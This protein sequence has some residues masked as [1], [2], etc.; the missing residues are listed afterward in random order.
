MRQYLSSMFNLIILVASYFLLADPLFL[1]NYPTIRAQFDLAFDSSSYSC[2]MDQAA[3]SLFT[4]VLTGF[5]LKIAAPITINTI[6]HIVSYITKKPFF[7]AEFNMPRSTAYLLDFMGMIFLSI[8]FAPLAVV[9]VPLFIF[10]KFKMEI[11]IAFAFFQKPQKPWKSQKAGEVHRPLIAPNYNYTF[12]SPDSLSCNLLCCATDIRDVLPHVLSDPGLLRTGLLLLEP[13]L[14]QELLDTGQ[15][16]RA[17]LGQHQQLCQQL[18]PR[19]GGRLLHLG[20]RQ[21][22]HY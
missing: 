7:R 12:N 4:L 20:Q 5:S 14:R 11:L 1:A 18:H 6:K 19:H 3:Q 17:V 13:D 22:R 16:P 10:I 2:R 21:L 8:P 15:S 9:F